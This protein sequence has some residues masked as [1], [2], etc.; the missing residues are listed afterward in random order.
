MEDR[1]ADVAG[2]LGQAGVVVADRFARQ[3]FLR[4]ERLQRGLRHDVA[5]DADRI[6]GDAAVL[7]GGEI[8]RLDRR[9]GGRIGRLQPDMT[10]ARRLHIGDARGE[11]RERVQRIAEPVERQRLHVILDVGALARRI[12]A[13]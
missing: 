6:R 10:A 11:R 8:I 13:R 3:I 7:V 2:G 5:R 1:G 12:G 9:R 4:M